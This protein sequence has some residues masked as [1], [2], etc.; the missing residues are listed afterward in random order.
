MNNVLKS[1]LKHLTTQKDFPFVVVLRSWI[2]WFL[3]VAHNFWFLLA[4]VLNVPILYDPYKEWT[5]PCLSNRRYEYTIYIYI[6]LYNIYWHPI[7]VTVTERCSDSQWVEFRLSS[8]TFD[9][10]FYRGSTKRQIHESKF[11]R[12]FSCWNH[13]LKKYKKF[14]R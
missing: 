10:K 2:F 11:Q 12:R 8:L 1:E 13:L 3:T 9:L 7:P 14:R 4:T 5:V 6:Y